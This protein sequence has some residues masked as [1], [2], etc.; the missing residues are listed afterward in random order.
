[1]CRAIQFFLTFDT[2]HRL[3][4]PVNRGGSNVHPQSQKLYIARESFRNVIN[5]RQLSVQHILRQLALFLDTMVFDAAPAGLCL[6]D[7]I[8]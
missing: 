5:N 4:V 6:N 2:K 8:H 1:M 7:F 3:S